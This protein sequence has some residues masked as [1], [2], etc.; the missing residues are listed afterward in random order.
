MDV[1]GELDAR[2][3]RGKLTGKRVETSTPAPAV[4]IHI[5]IEADRTLGAA[6]VN[7]GVAVLRSVSVVNQTAR[8]ISGLTVCLRANP[9]L[10]DDLILRLD[11]LGVGETHESMPVMPVNL[12]RLSQLNE[13]TPVQIAAEVLKDGA[14]LASTS[15][16]VDATAWDEWPGERAIPELLAAFCLPNDPQIERLL[17]AAAERA[18]LQQTGF[19]FDGYQSMSREAV[20]RQVSALWN[21]IRAAG[22]SYVVPPASFLA[23]GQKVRTPDR[24]FENR[25]GTCLDLSLLFAG[26]LEQAGLRPVLLLGDGHAWVGVWLHPTSFGDTV[27]DDVQAVRKRIAS[28]EFIAIETTVLTAPADQRVSLRDATLRGGARLG[29][30]GAASN[31]P[32]DMALDVLRCRQAKILPLPSRIPARRIAGQAAYPNRAGSAQDGVLEPLPT[33][34]PLDPLTEDITP[35]QEN[36]ATRL[37]RWKSRLLDLTLR[38]RLLNFRATKSTLEIAAPDLGRLEDALAEG[39]EF[40]FVLPPGSPTG[41]GN[42]KQSTRTDP[43]KKAIDRRGAITPPD[44]EYVTAALE[45]GELV[46]N[47]DRNE[48]ETRLQGIW[49]A[50]RESVEEGGANTLFLALGFLE[51]TQTDAAERKFLAPI[52][53]VPVTLERPSVRSGY[54]LR[55]HDDE[56]IVNPTLLEHLR[57]TFDQTIPG[58]EGLPADEKGIDV[59]GVLQTVRLAITARKHWEVKDMAWLG[60][61]SFTK[62]LMWKDLEDRADVLKRHPLIHH[63]IENAGEALP[64]PEKD[65]RLARLDDHFAPDALLLPL[66]ADSSQQRAVCAID[67]GQDLVLEG[68]PGTGK[69]QTITN[70][71][72]HA[73]ARGKSVLF[74][75]EKMAALDVVRRRLVNVGLGGFCLELHSSRA[76]KTEVLR[77]LGE[78]LQLAGTDAPENWS[79]EAARL[80]GLRAA[81]NATVQAMH[82]RYPNGF[83]VFTAIGRVLGAGVQVEP[84][85]PWTTPDHHD[86]TALEALRLSVRRL[87]TLGA[88]LGAIGEHPLRLV[89]QTAWSM[90]LQDELKSTLDESLRQLRQVHEAARTLSGIVG[91]DVVAA[92]FDRLHSLAVLGSRLEDALSI[93]PGF[94]AKM[95]DTGVRQRIDSLVR[96]GRARFA[97]WRR[98][99]AEW[100]EEVATVHAGVIRSEW[101]DE[102]SRFWPRAWFAKRAIRKRL[103][104]FR[105]DGRPPAEADVTALLEPLA[106]VNEEDGFLK[107]LAPEAAE[108]LGESFRQTGTDWDQVEGWNRWAQALAAAVDGVARTDETLRSGLVNRLAAILGEDRG[109]LAAEGRVT[110][111]FVDWKIRWQALEDSCARLAEQVLPLET[112]WGDHRESRGLHRLQGCLEM[113]HA[114]LRQL[115]PWCQ[116]RTAREEAERLGLGGLLEQIEQGDLVPG[117]IAETFEQTYSSWWL[118]KAIDREPVLR[119]FSRADQ[120]RTIDDFR[121]LDAQF[122]HLTEQWIAATLTARL[123]VAGQ[124]PPGAGS[125]MGVLQRELAKQRRHM[126]VRQ[127]VKNLPTLLPRLKPCLLMS[128][129]SV[130]QYLDAD[131][132]PFDLVIFDEASQIPVWDAIGVIA[133]GRQLVV[134]GDPKQLPPTRFFDRDVNDSALVADTPVIDEMESILDECLGVGLNR[135]S[136]TW[137]YR[138]R[139]ESLITFSNRR[140]YDDRLSTS[141]SPVT[142]DR[143]VH[144]EPVPGFY[145]RGGSRTN[146]IEAEAVVAAIET[147]FLASRNHV[148]SLGVVTFNQPQQLLIERLLDARRVQVPALDNA[149]AAATDEP[150][151]IKNLENV[152]GDERDLILFSVTYGRDASGRMALNF[153]PLNGEGGHRRLN[154]AITRAREAVVVF[155]SLQP[156]EIDLSRV[157]ARGV[158]DLRHYLEFARS[159]SEGDAPVRS[160]ATAEGRIETDVARALAERGFEVHFGIGASGWKVDLAVVDPRD[161]SRYLAGIEC[162]GEGWRDAPTARDRDRL[163]PHVLAGL[164]WTLFRIWSMEWWL[165]PV[166]IVDRIIA[167]LKVLASKPLRETEPVFARPAKAEPRALPDPASEPVVKAEQAALDPVPVPDVSQAAAKPEEPGQPPVPRRRRSTDKAA[168]AEAPPDAI[169]EAGTPASGPVPWTAPGEPRPLRSGPIDRES[170]RLALQAR[171]RARLAK[172]REGEAPTTEISGMTV[173]SLGLTVFKPA[174]LRAT[175]SRHFHEPAADRLIT[176]TLRMI[177]D[178]EAPMAESVLL[179][180]ASRAWG[181]DRTGPRVNQR[182]LSLLPQGAHRTEDDEEPFW[183]SGKQDPA[184]WRNF[185]IAGESEV[186]RRSIYETARAEIALMI[187]HVLDAAGATAR[188]ELARSVCRMVGMTRTTADAETRVLRQVQRMVEAGELEEAAERISLSRP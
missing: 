48:L 153:G 96:H 27:E 31:P 4:D 32:F 69:S 113:W 19:A 7:N 91:F 49:R 110:R 106:A 83:S 14:L 171:M 172:Q 111:A 173:P 50:A 87:D 112:P 55:R 157:R 104:G 62:Y 125:E 64:Q 5:R 101:A 169:R 122:Q 105:V 103:A 130:A 156:E 46:I 128:P 108:L 119:G 30:E 159:R 67:A 140:Y 45:R 90:T 6:A 51:W 66:L 68:P 126:P 57:V 114:N 24:V 3:A 82:R 145:D 16:S 149:I 72:A 76:R 184:T 154:V 40:R 58:L 117:N 170:M 175:G 35:S 94:A 10:L 118:R 182:L 121:K 124:V 36:A 44:S 115:S 71:I 11:S 180:K 84:A 176:M 99:A 37:I 137:H 168:V 54:L 1:V 80:G 185:R 138:S 79:R 167:K 89:G 179:K 132:P 152:Q 166:T 158:H 25:V 53:L 127:L 133:R 151:F 165:D 123:P 143:A 2:N 160:R 100:T 177:I 188:D 23:G 41:A 65:P 12:E 107:A 162:D 47:I 161:A 98:L 29:S 86:Q 75:S 43:L 142:A 60:H 155:S 139:H 39:N 144:I 147:H 81:L 163:R 131:Y 61:F 116:W 15:V 21:E 20:W 77:Q 148:P 102:S 187:R 93:P 88:A 52:I 28:G 17:G 134:V 33:L 9:P 146:P 70:V 164:G 181:F 78:S 186:S 92:D 174:E 141:P 13:S 97:A 150:L 95:V 38:N 42:R 74:V 22:L 85:Y 129:L 34:P 18:R 73:L 56:A 8:T 26:L 136:L 109:A 59:P 135:Q 183:W 120:E 178:A 63:L